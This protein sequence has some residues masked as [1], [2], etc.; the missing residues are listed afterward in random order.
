MQPTGMGCRASAFSHEV[1]EIY[2]RTYNNAHE[3]QPG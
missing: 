3:L 1:E 2:G